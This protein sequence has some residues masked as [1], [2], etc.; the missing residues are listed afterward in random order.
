MGHAASAGSLEAVYQAALQCVQFGIGVERA[1]LLRFDASGSMRFVAWTGLSDEYRQAVEGHS[2]WTPE[3]TNAVP[4]LISDTEKDPALAPYQSEFTREGIRALAF[5]PLQFG[6]R[7]L[8]KFMLYYAEPHEFSD[9]EISTAEQIANYVV[10]SLE[11]HRLAVALNE[12]LASE[13]SLRRHA[14]ESENRLHVALAA[15]Q[16][17]TWELDV[18]SGRNYWSE[19]LERMHGL[20]PGSFDGSQETAMSFVHPL[21]APRF[22]DMVA[23]CKPSV[24]GDHEVEFRIVRPDGACRWIASRGRFLFDRDGKPTRMVGVCSDITDLKRLAEIAN[25]ADRRKDEFL[26]TLAHELRNPLAAVRTGVAVIRKANGDAAAVVEHCTVMERQL[27]QLTRL[28]DDLLDIADITRRGLPLEKTRIELSVIVRMALEQGQELVEEAGHELKVRVPT[29][30]IM[31][32]ADPARV[33]QVLTNLLSNAVKYTPPGGRITLSAEREGEELRLSVKDNGIGI[34]AEKLEYVF[35]MFGQLDRSLE[36]GYK[37][38]GIGLALARALVSKHGGRIRA[39]SEGLGKGSEFS[40]WLPLAKA[41]ASLRTLGEPAH[42]PVAPAGCRV[43]MVDDNRDVAVGM[44]RLIRLL[45]H[46]VRMALNGA[47][48]L[49]IVEEFQPDVVLL[50]IAMPEMNGYE[51]ARTLRSQPIGREMTLV[52]VTGWGRDHDKHRSAEVGFDRHMTKPVDPIVLEAFLESIAR[53]KTSSPGK[54]P[55][56]TVRD[57]AANVLR[58]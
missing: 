20:A 19:E 25:E 14:E 29:E 10:L 44:S 43:L 13:R 6:S 30:S 55:W 5:I 41:P 47:Q 54:P 40:I 46:E 51:V 42:D 3:E 56:K 7:V 22:A 8:G 35:E 36:T 27:R 34:P 45:G 57:E 9:E 26:A 32:D 1:S 28:V 11:H 53:R 12:Q 4:L 58:Q 15:G 17:G 37:G 16:M 31:L 48:A 39:H 52:A 23:N 49:E 18:V 24:E 50:D 21:D 2:P 38:L 33:V